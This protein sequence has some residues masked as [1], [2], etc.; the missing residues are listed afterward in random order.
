MRIVVDTNVIVSALVF[1]GPPRQA[2]D[3][4]A[5]GACEL[6]FS[7]PI[8]GEVER[9]LESKFGWSREEIHARLGVLWGWGTRIHPRVLLAVIADDPDDDCILE[10]AVAARAEAIISGDHHLVRLGSFQSIP[11]QTPRQFLESKP[12]QN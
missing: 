4:V 12:W 3:L 10:C 7:A 9:I 6:Y 2:L 8:Q 5:E 11:I 1:G